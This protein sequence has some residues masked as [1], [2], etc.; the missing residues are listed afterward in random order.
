MVLIVFFLFL[1]LFSF[2]PIHFMEYWHHSIA[3]HQLVHYTSHCIIF[4]LCSFS[5]PCLSGIVSWEPPHRILCNRT[6]VSSFVPYTFS[7]YPVGYPWLHPVWDY[8]ITSTL[9]Y[10]VVFLPI[11]VSSLCSPNIVGSFALSKV[12][13]ELWAFQDAKKDR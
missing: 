11:L 3:H 4:A 2:L 10:S 8:C 13:S 5:C 9:V 7:F 12:A 1:C 6:T